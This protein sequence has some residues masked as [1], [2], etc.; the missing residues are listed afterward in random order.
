MEEIAQK[1]RS[2]NKCQLAKG[3]TNAVP[4]EGPQHATMM[5]V[6]EAPGSAEDTS[7]RPFIG[8]SG[9][10]LTDTMTSVG[11]QREN[12]FITNI[13][14]CRPPENRDPTDKEI[15][16]CA[17]YVLSQMDSIS[18]V[19][20]V[21]L[22]NVSY[23]FFSTTFYLPKKQVGEVRGKVF[24]LHSTGCKFLIPTYHPA[25]VIYNRKLQPDF[26]EDLRKAERYLKVPS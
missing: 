19:V 20:L 3:R 26:I 10:L 22:G 12:V 21:T 4:G 16:T 11:I 8:Q 15:G 17:P 7:G 25:A 24:R 6:G 18:P 13:V 1:I 9:K 2:C 23:D 14:K 5:L